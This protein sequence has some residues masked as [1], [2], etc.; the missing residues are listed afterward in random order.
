MEHCRWF[1]NNF[2]RGYLKVSIIERTSR[3]YE[4][5]TPIVLCKPRLMCPHYNV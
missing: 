1:L 4:L 3:F 2:F 5:F